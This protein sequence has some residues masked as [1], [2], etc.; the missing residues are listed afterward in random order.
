VIQDFDAL[1]DAEKIDLA[2]VTN[3][4]DFTDL[5]TNHM[6]QTGLDVTITDGADTITLTNTS[7]ANLDQNDFNFVLV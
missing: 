6:A 4:T 1:V 2:A 3:I 5:S 7:L